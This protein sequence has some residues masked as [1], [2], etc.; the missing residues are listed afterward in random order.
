MPTVRSEIGPYRRPVRALSRVAKKIITDATPMK[1]SFPSTGGASQVRRSEAPPDAI[2]AGPFLLGH[3]DSRVVDREIFCSRESQQ[4]EC[5]TFRGG[6]RSG[7]NAEL[8]TQNL[9]SRSD[10][11]P[12]RNPP[13]V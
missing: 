8:Q 3:I 4:R 12:T 7:N 13:V 2:A 11:Q 9:V 1:S 6:V 5:Q 10:G